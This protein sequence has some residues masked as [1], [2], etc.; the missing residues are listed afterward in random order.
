MKDGCRLRD[1]KVK[2]ICSNSQQGVTDPVAKR[3][4]IENTCKDGEGF[5][6]NL[7]DKSLPYGHAEP[8]V[9]QSRAPLACDTC[10]PPPKKNKTVMVKMLNSKPQNESPQ[11][12]G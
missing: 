7:T 10:L 4:L 6:T 11:T 3:N 9:Y 2:L 12:S 8:L 1:Q 5:R